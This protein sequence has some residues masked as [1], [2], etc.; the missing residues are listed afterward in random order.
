MQFL[1]VTLTLVAIFVLGDMAQVKESDSYLTNNA[2]V[3]LGEISYDL[4]QT[5][6]L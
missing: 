5:P 6:L 3:T 1:L 4:V 2:I